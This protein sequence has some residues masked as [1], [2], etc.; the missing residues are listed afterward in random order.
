MLSAVEATTSMSVQLLVMMVAGSAVWIKSRGRT[1]WRR[2]T[3]RRRHPA[4][5]ARFAGAAAA[6]VAGAVLVT[7]MAA[8]TK[9]RPPVPKADLVRVLDPMSGQTGATFV[10][11][12]SVPGLRERPAPLSYSGA[13]Y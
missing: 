13:S 3:D 12:N 8:T 1:T 9:P 2:Q 4:R 11:Y 7:G 6:V 10:L 5:A